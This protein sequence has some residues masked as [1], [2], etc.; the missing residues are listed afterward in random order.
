M[1]LTSSVTTELPRFCDHRTFQVIFDLC[2]FPSLRHKFHDNRVTYHFVLYFSL[3]LNTG[4]GTQQALREC[5]V[6]SWVNEGFSEKSVAQRERLGNSPTALQLEG[7]P[8]LLRDLHCE[9]RKGSNERQFIF[10]N[11]ASDA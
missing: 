10:I 7:S 5:V 4:P 11:N 3:F 2:L 1:N 6:H 9:N 8:C